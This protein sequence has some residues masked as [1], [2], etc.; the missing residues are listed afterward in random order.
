MRRLWRISL[1]GMARKLRLEYEGAIYHVMN[2]GDRREDIFV[3]ERDRARFMETLGEACMK[4]DWQVHGYCLMCNHFHLVIETPQPNLSLRMNQH[5]G[6][7]LAEA[8][9]QKAE[10]L[11]LEMLARAGWTEEDPV[12]AP[13]SAGVTVHVAARLRRETTASWK[14]IAQR[15]GMGH[16]RSAANAVRLDRH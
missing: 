2:R 15:L 9:D 5:C 7:E 12:R 16:G 14:R 8:A 10:R 3:D 1:Q 6:D 13:K 4:T 11:M